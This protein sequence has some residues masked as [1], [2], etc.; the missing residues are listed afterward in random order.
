MLRWFPDG[1]R[2][3]Q[4]ARDKGLSASTSYRYLN[5]GLAS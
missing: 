1:T 3:A 2:L 4:L 5:E